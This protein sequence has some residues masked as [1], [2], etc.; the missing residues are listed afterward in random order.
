VRSA[1]EARRRRPRVA[2]EARDLRER[3]VVSYAD[4]ITLL[5]AFFV[6]MYAIS[7]VD[8][9]KF[10]RVSVGVKSAFE[11]G[12]RGAQPVPLEWSLPGGAGG[13]SPEALEE[14]TPSAQRAGARTPQ[15]AAVRDA[16]EGSLGRWITPE[17]GDDVVRMAATPRGFVVSLSAGHLF[18]PGSDRLRPGAERIL[19]G[20]GS[21]LETVHAPVRLEGHTDDTPIRS[22]RFPSNWEL[23]TARATRVLRHLLERHA[24]RPE[25]LSVAG[26]GAFR[27]LVPNDSPENRARNRRVDVVLVADPGA[28]Y[29]PPDAEGE[30][31]MLLD[32][33]PPL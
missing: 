13:R 8:T 32:R 20:I 11:E 18:E 5:F 17:L 19:E 4:F 24:L 28:G 9:Q 16:L 10:E 23:S 30:L 14:R 33:L 2:P 15:W 7:T 27:P 21:V 3:W 25:R 6:V 26:Y 12:P 22:E 1:R 29:E 31:G